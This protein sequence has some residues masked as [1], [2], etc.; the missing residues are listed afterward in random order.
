MGCVGPSDDGWQPPPLAQQRGC[1]LHGPAPACAGAWIAPPPGGSGQRGGEGGI[2]T[3]L[4]PGGDEGR[5]SSLRDHRRAAG[6]RSQH[7]AA[8][9]LASARV[10]CLT[11][12][13]HEGVAVV[14]HCPCVLVWRSAPLGLSL[15][16]LWSLGRRRSAGAC[17]HRAPFHWPTLT[18]YRLALAGR[19]RGP[20]VGA[21]GS[22]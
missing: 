22:A 7:A 1:Q 21:P 17:P 14:N 5:F 3:S 11:E 10:F 13:T 19:A 4:P 8:P 18:G 2:K 16:W 15:V 20:P 12:G 9:V 6:C